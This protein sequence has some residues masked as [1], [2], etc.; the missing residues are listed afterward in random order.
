[1]KKNVIFISI[2]AFI[3]CLAME[4][5][6]PL[7]IA[8]KPSMVSPFT[9]VERVPSLQVQSTRALIK[10]IKSYEDINTIGQKVPAHLRCEYA[11]ELIKGF[12]FTSYENEKLL[13][14][15]CKNDPLYYALMAY[16][17]YRDFLNGRKFVVVN[18]A[19]T[20]D[21]AKNSGNDFGYRVAIILD[22]ATTQGDSPTALA[23]R[24][25]DPQVYGFLRSMGIKPSTPDLSAAIKKHDNF[26]VQRLLQLGVPADDPKLELES[27]PL[28][29]ALDKLNEPM[30]ASLL[31][32][33]ASFNTVYK[34]MHSNEKES[35]DKRF[36]DKIHYLLAN[37]E[38]HVFYEKTLEE[39]NA[40]LQR[41]LEILDQQ[42]AIEES[43]KSEENWVMQKVHQLRNLFK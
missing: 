35:I 33:G 3:S 18:I 37:P 26:L 39:F 36:R 23:I 29:Y 32:A 19:R 41:Q 13:D 12:N 34:R 22:S 10:K 24:A 8:V 31:K 14:T 27:Q 20:A 16:S 2:F 30:I 6:T 42:K 1:M 11:K 38:A 15:F 9:E 17:Y 28:Y 43:R 21:I 40:F 4:K 5:P 25:Q 7:A